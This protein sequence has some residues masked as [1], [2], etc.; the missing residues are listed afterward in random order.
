MLFCL[1]WHPQRPWLTCILYHLQI[2]CTIVPLQLW[3]GKNN[4]VFT[5]NAKCR[6]VLHRLAVCAVTS[7]INLSGSATV[8]VDLKLSVHMAQVFEDML[9][10]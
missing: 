6:T 7:G 3:K 5:A 10:L 1:V 8:F 2:G 4:Y 9:C